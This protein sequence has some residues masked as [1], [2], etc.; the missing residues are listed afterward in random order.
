MYLW[1]PTPCLN[2]FWHAVPTSLYIFND[3]VFI[4]VG[5]TRVDRLVNGWTLLYIV[6]HFCVTR[7]C[8]LAS[9]LAYLYSICV[10]F[11]V[12]LSDQARYS[13]GAPVWAV[14]LRG[15]PIHSCY[16]T[17]A[18]STIVEIELGLTTWNR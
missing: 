6:K 11:L 12:C 2:A 18:V 10:S 3:I 17:G 5:Y 14:Q 13:H 9:A 16:N 4:I 15:I 8:V 7:G 1:I